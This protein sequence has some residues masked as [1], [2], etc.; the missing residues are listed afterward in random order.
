MTGALVHIGYHK[1]GTTW[2]QKRFYPAVDHA[3]FVPRKLVRSAIIEPRAFDFSPDD[4]RD[5]ILAFT[6]G[7]RPLLCEENLSGYLHNGGLGGLLSR[8]VADRVHAIFPDAQIV[9]LLR[10]QPSMVAAAYAQYVLAGGTLDL[11]G[12]VGRDR[13]KGTRKYWYK[14]PAFDFRHLDYGPLLDHYAERF[15]K[16][17]INVHLFEQFAEDASGFAR[18]LSARHQLELDWDKLEFTRENPS[19]SPRQLRILARLNLL[20]ARSVPNKRWL[21]DWGHWYDRRWTWL[22]RT[23]RVIGRWVSNEPLLSTANEAEIAAMFAAGN[24]RLESIWA[25]PLADYGYPLTRTQSPRRP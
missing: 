15:G 2:F 6:E 12:Y 23:E 21:A 20:T 19:L 18:R 9:V 5:R 10:S 16:A 11:P 7:R 14:A 13:K 3:A 1:T 24:D 4:A 22:A 25:L 17:A 8:E